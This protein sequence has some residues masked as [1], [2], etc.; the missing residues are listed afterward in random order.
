MKDKVHV[1]VVGTSEYTDYRAMIEKAGLDAIVV[2]TPD[3]LHYPI[4]MLALEAGLHVLCEKPLAMNANDAKEMLHAAES[5]GLVHMTMLEWRDVPEVRQM[6]EMVRRGD[7]GVVQTFTACSRM[8]FLR[9]PD[10]AWRIDA[11]HGNGVAGDLGSH[12]IDR[13]RLMIGE[14]T[15]VSAHL[16]Y[17][18][19]RA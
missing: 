10:Y 15:Q 1:G 3:D 14:I 8:G 5:R 17:H 6:V 2:S 4:T 11:A 19:Q 18:Y 9:S 13:A 12:M 7:V 16:A